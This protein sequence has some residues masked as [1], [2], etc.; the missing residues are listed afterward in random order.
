MLRTSIV[1]DSVP[2]AF[3]GSVTP[4]VIVWTPRS[5]QKLL[6]I[7]PDSTGMAA[8]GR[9]HW[10]F[11]APFGDSASVVSEPFKVR[12]AFDPLH[13]IRTLFVMFG[14]KLASGLAT[15]LATG[16]VFS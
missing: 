16:A 5:R 11:N 8:G 4:S 3:C 9:N 13:E 14:W 15:N 7:I 10:K 6:T 1:N 12:H 2:E